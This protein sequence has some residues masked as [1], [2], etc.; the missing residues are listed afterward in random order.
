MVANGFGVIRSPEW[1]VASCKTLD[2]QPRLLRRG[3]CRDTAPTLPKARGYQY[4][5]TGRFAMRGP[6][7][8]VLPLEDGSAQCRKT[9][10]AVL[11]LLRPTTVAM[12]V[13]E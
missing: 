6:H 3:L 4:R 5:T 13:S 1:M 8:R 2:H 10:V 12:L 11:G 7:A 9:L